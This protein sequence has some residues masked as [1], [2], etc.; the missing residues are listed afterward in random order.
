MYIVVCIVSRARGCQGEC[1][2][3]E[4]CGD[5]PWEALAKSGYKPIKIQKIN[6]SFYISGYLL[7]TPAAFL[8]LNRIPGQNLE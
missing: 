2:F 7:E 4:F 5:H 8:P 1:L 6:E 3:K